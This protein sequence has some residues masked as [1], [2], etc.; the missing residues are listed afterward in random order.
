LQ[1]GPGRAQQHARAVQDE[2]HGSPKTHR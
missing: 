1:R 2:K